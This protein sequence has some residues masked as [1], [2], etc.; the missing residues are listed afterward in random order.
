MTV[1]AYIG[2][3]A[4][5]IWVLFALGIVLLVIEFLQPG[6]GAPGVL[7]VIAIVVGIILQAGTLIEALIMLA[8]LAVI[9]CL[10]GI[11]FVRSLYKGRISKSSIMLRDKGPEGK[12]ASQ[13]EDYLGKRGIAL[14]DLRPVGTASFD[15]ERINVLTE[16]EYIKKD[17]LIEV[18]RVKGLDVIVRSLNETM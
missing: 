14:T 3:F 9:V 1:F 8:V 2:T 6:I 18:T 13:Y 5:Y 4:W 17:E 16:G 11:I 15:G 10:I 7:G 12:A